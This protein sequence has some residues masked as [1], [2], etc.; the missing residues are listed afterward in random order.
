MTDLNQG[1]EVHGHYLIV[2]RRPDGTVKWTDT[3]ENLVTT[4][5]KN[6]LLTMGLTNGT[7]KAAWYL[8][9][10]NATPTPNVA[11]TMASH[12]GWTENENYTEATREVW[13]DGAVAAGSVDNSGAVAT[14][15]IDTD[16]QTIG[17]AFLC[18]IST[19]GGTTGVLY[20]A[21][22]FTGGNKALDNGETIDVTATFTA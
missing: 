13:T 19:K 8:G 1:V 9:L 4:V 22:A 2:C 20:S 12:G 15:S 7:P 16:T 5:G 14:F 10:T 11:D 21:G 3:I 17:G 18:D 6:E